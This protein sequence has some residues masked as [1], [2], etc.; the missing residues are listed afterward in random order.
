MDENYAGY[1]QYNGKKGTHALES[2]KD[3]YQ[4]LHWIIIVIITI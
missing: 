4:K 3:I 1:P 2:Q